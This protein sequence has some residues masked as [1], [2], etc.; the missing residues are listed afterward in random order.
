MNRC[1]MFPS[2]GAAA[3]LAFTVAHTV[4]V[5]ETIETQPVRHYMVPFVCCRHLQVVFAFH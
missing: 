1:M 5:A 3:K 2:A 4:P